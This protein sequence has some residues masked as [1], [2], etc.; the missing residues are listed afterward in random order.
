MSKIDKENVVKDVE[1]FIES[2][3]KVKKVKKEKVKKEVTGHKKGIIVTIV[4]CVLTTILVIAA[5][6]IVNYLHD[7][8]VKRIEEEAYIKDMNDS[9]ANLLSEIKDLQIEYND[10]GNMDVGTVLDL[11]LEST[12][13][14]Y[15][16]YFDDKGLIE[17]GKLF[18][19]IYNEVT[20][21]SNL[22]MDEVYCIYKDDKF[23]CSRDYKKNTGVNSASNKKYQI[24][25]AVTLKDGSKW[26]VVRN[27]SEYS[28]YVYLLYDGTIAPLNTYEDNGNVDDYA[29]GWKF[30]STGRKYFWERDKNNLGYWLEN[31]IKSQFKIDEE[32]YLSILSVS[33]YQYLSDKLSRDG[34]TADK[35]EGTTSAHWFFNHTLRCWWLYDYEDSRP[36]ITLWNNGYSDDSLGSIASV[37]PTSVYNLR[38]TMTVKKSAIQ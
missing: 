31:D 6:V 38:P 37:N 35:L 16:Y 24:G 11:S 15:F 8:E 27:S 28:E 34:L 21:I 23:D 19:D 20:V 30:D 3:K 1:S 10:Y 18:I 5:N 22:K 17:E 32:I 26:H 7:L 9:A 14:D 2:E 13:D 4:I 29:T 36:V 33:E 25:D 12:I